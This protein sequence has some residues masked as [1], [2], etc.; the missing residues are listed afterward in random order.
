MKLNAA[1]KITVP[2]CL[3]FLI[4]THYYICWKLCIIKISIFNI[5]EKLY[6]KEN[7]GLNLAKI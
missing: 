3:A 7:K 5:I 1:Y 4:V 2:N 6:L